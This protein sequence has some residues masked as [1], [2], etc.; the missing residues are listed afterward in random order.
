[1]W[2]SLEDLLK[3][4]KQQEVGKDD[5]KDVREMVQHLF[6]DFINPALC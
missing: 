3:I 5:E 4:M 6:A 1:V 2:D